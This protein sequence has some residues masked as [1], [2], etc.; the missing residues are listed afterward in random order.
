MTNTGP[1][2]AA[3]RMARACVGN[4]ADESELLACARIIDAEIKPLVE[5]ASNAADSYNEQTVPGSNG[6]A[7][8]ILGREQVDALRSALNSHK[9]REGGVS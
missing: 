8:H 9:S 4:A 6:K 5:A 2:E 3:K 7:Y 1:S